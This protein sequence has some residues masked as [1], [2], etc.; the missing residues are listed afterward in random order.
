MG[1]VFCHYFIGTVGDEGQ[2]RR[3]R[4]TLEG[5]I[6][7]GA[8]AEGDGGLYSWQNGEGGRDTRSGGTPRGDSPVGLV[9]D[10]IGSTPSPVDQCEP[11]LMRTDLWIFRIHIA[12]LCP[13]THSFS[14]SC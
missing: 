7:W 12:R 14:I 5:K 3:P 9:G 13:M 1:A 4:V 6:T 11:G 2:S 10:K 8:T